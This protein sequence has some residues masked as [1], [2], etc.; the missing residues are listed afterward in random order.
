[1]HEMGQG[2]PRAAKEIAYMASNGAGKGR[3]ARGGNARQTRS[4]RINILSSGA[5]GPEETPGEGGHQRKSGQGGRLV[6]MPAG[7]RG[8]LGI[9][10]HVPDGVTPEGFSRHLKEA[11]A[12]FRGVVLDE[13]LA[14]IVSDDADLE[15]TVRAARDKWAAQ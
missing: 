8:G 15:T 3:S 5:V 14:S 2:D 13:F 11:S 7:A 6:E 1:M 10:Q 9:F 4:F 12:K